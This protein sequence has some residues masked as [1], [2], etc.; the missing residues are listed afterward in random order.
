MK[1]ASSLILTGTNRR[2]YSKQWARLETCLSAAL[3]VNGLIP[4][5]PLFIRGTF[6]FLSVRGTLKTSLETW[7]WLSTE[8]EWKQKLMTSFLPSLTKGKLPPHTNETG[9]WEIMTWWLMLLRGIVLNSTDLPLQKECTN[10]LE[11]SIKFSAAILTKSHCVLVQAEGLNLDLKA[12][13]ESLP[14]FYISI[15]RV[16]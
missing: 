1:A 14:H 2:I 15:C 9:K 16:R 7:A 8:G 3:A 5:L 13:P 4:S 11:S 12:T 10:P 6:P